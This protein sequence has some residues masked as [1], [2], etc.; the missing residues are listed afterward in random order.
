MYNC[1]R[2]KREVRIIKQT[3]SMTTFEETFDFARA[4]D[5]I[6]ILIVMWDTRSA[7]R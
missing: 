5:I 2:R 6:N 3:S 7:V 4:R 1:N